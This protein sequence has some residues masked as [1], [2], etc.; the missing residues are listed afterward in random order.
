MRSRYW[1][2]LICLALAMPVTGAAQNTD[3][4]TLLTGNDLRAAFAGRTHFGTYKEYREL[5]GTN[6]FTEKMSADGTTD[7]K[8]GEMRLTGRWNIVNDDNM[9]FL[10]DDFPGLHCFMMFQSGTCIYGYNPDWVSGDRPLRGN[11]WTVKSV[12]NG[13]VS[14]CDDLIG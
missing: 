3:E 4:M 12:R 5:T 14:T 13:D 6:Q 11:A 8:E 7:Y 10:Y 2:S 9:C 1:I